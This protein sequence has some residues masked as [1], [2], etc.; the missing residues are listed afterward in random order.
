MSSPI[1]QRK[2]LDP[3][4]T[5]APPRVRAQSEQSKQWEA[6]PTMPNAAFAP[7]IDWPWKSESG[8]SPAFRGD[9]AV[10]AMQRRLT[11][12]PEWIPEPPRSSG[13]SRTVWKLLLRMAAAVAVTALIAWAMVSTPGAALFE[14]A[15]V[16]AS[17]LGIANAFSQHL[18]FLIAAARPDRV[19]PQQGAAEKAGRPLKDQSHVGGRIATPVAAAGLAMAG[20]T[21][22]AMPPP[23]V[24]A[25]AAA[26]VA[27]PAPPTALMPPPAMAAT[28]APPASTMPTPMMT[29]PQPPPTQTQPA[30]VIRQLDRDELASLLK[31]GEDLI[32]SGDLSSARLAL[33]RAAEAGDARAALLLAGTYDPNL[34]DKLGFQEH[35]ADVALARLWYQRAQQFGSAE[36]PRRLQQLATKA[37]SV[38]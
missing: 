8:T 17:F 25:P 1:H 12:E 20:T 28:P 38:P 35:A 3:A 9:R 27:T 13:A 31:R 34:L 4:L 15:A 19:D 24:V 21:T 14:N 36:A 37:N 7:P 26:V 23:A 16:R 5:F 22:P 18:P 33:R 32:N 11:L 29:S 30:L 10:R 2:D 6:M